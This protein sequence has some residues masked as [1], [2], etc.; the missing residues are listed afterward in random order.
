MTG[1]QYNILYK[2]SS[3]NVVLD[4]VELEIV[5]EPQRIWGIT[6]NV[7]AEANQGLVRVTIIRWTL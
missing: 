7:F 5:R 2:V 4:L 6:V 3:E 1:N